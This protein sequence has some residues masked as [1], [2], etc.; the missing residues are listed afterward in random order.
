M[1][2][3][4]IVD[5]HSKTNRIVQ[6]RYPIWQTLLLYGGAL[7]L[8]ALGLWMRLHDLGLPFDRDGYD[9]GVYWQSLHAMSNGYGLYSQ[10]FYSQ[11]PFFLLSLFPFY[12]LFGHTLWAA[13]LGVAIISLFGLLGA[14]AIGR[15]LGGRIGALLALLLFVV[16]P[17]YLAQSQVIQAE[18]PSVAFSFLAVGMAYLWWETPGG[19]AGSCFAI[20][21]GISTLR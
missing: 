11:P 21:S 3:S 7:A 8:I 6:Q 5:A 4:A 9:E 18:A 10:I 20:L 15:A 1:S 19:F 17:S 12:T 13:R 16:D 14:F 2:I